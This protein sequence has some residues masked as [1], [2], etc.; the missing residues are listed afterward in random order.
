MKKT[1]L[2][3]AL[4]ALAG[5]ALADGAYTGTRT[6]GD[7]KITLKAWG[8]GTIS[9]TDELVFEGAHSLRIST[10]NYFQ[11]GRILFGAPVKLAD[12]FSNKDN[13][14]I[15]NFRTASGS[16]TLGAG[17]KGGGGGAPGG[18]AGFGGGIGGQDG[19]APGGGG[20]PGKGG[21]GGGGA[22]A[23]TGTPAPL[24]MVRVIVT[25]T[26]GLKSEAYSVI[27]AGSDKGWTKLGVPLQGLAGFSRTNKEIKEIAL[28]GD[29]T[30]SFYVGGVGILNDASPIQADMNYR[31]D[32]NVGASTELE[33][34]GN[35]YGGATPLKYSWDFD[36]DGQVDAEGQS[37][38]RRFRKEGTWKVTLTVSDVYGLKKPF[39]TSINVKVNP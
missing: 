21:P 20:R 38:K 35:G 10:R 14:L 11:G 7:Q 3:T 32:L 31:A 23:A 2:I 25:T 15:L 26:D 19:G 33:F 5:S 8:S 30:G 24:K 36:G 34:I 39:T 13:L 17:G 1:W 16:T 27:P 37:V 18:P 12:S 22:P 28:S 6:I 4:I 9:E 29:A